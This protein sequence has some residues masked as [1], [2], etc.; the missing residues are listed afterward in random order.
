MA[1][2]A[3]SIYPALQD[4]PIKNTICLFD[5]DETLTPARQTVTPEMLML[6]SQLRHKCA[7]GYVGGSN[8]VKQQEQLG[9]AATD[10]TSLFDFCFPENG[11]MAF[12]L[13]KPLAS[14]SFIEWIGE[15]KYQK[16][17][18]FI[19]KYFAD[20]QLPKK[21]GTFIEF[22]NGM[23]NVSPLGRNASVE[24]RN[25]FEAY[26]KEHH[27]R[28]DMV[29]ALKKEFPDYGLTYSIGGQISFDVF[30]TGWDK[31][32]C[33]RH[34]EAEK[35]ITGVEYTTIHFFGDK[36]FPGG[37]DYEIYSD[38]RTIGHSVHGPE[39]TMQQLKEL[40]APQKS[41]TEVPRSLLPRLT[42]NGSST[43][44]TVAPPQGNA[45]ST[46]RPKPQQRIQ[47]LN[48][49]CQQLRSLS[50]YPHQARFFPAASRNV[51][52]TT[53]VARCPSTSPSARQNRAALEDLNNPIRYNGVYVAV[54]KPARLAF[55]ASASRQREHHFDTL[56]FV[57]RL[58]DEGFSEEQAVAMMRVLNDV[59]QES[60]QHLTRTMVLREDTERSAYTQK[61]DF[62]KLRSE[63]LNAD[64]TEAQL[65]RS[66]HEKIAA[67]L[68]KLNSRLRDEIGR[69]QASVR[70][71]LNLEKGRI[72]EEANG[73]EMRIKET[74]TRIEQEVAGLRERV[75]AVK[76]STL[77]WLMGV[78]T[79]TAAL[80]LGA[81]R[82]FM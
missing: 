58:K 26:D 67:D 6:L 75:E 5:V 35:E 33:L 4:R 25:E 43:R 2:E 61:V 53:L 39:D 7:I 14:T 59:I 10:V 48:P 18:N 36:C 30:P 28:S 80:I 16:L 68:A 55:H 41:V 72:R 73:Q 63:L 38:P 9:T 11:L 49:V 69:T 47:N 40:M 24:E 81:W 32:Y 29:N 31:T 44:I 79:G 1:T 60:I 21:R 54:F 19:L 70:L 62:A 65:T 37:N 57:Q 8:L 51:S 20:L 78:C 45:L 17:V 13:G 12:R 46:L 42:W 27:I 56:R 34:V 74:E 77:Q 52:P 22:R 50:V 15:E 64:S 23:I 3:A 71:D 76:F 66:S 82:L